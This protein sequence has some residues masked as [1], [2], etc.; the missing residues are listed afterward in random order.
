MVVIA[1]LGSLNYIFD[2]LFREA[3]L[4]MPQLIFPYMFQYHLILPAIDAALLLI[5]FN[6][7]SFLK[8]GKRKDA[9]HLAD[10]AVE[11]SNR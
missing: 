6:G 7:L 4:T 11:S 2:R 10:E 5:V 1:F 3:V 9:I 8:K